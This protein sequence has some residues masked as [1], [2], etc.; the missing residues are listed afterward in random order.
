MS[1]NNKNKTVI[2]T[3]AGGGIGKA[4][5]FEFAK[6]GYKLI[7]IGRTIRDLK[8]CVKEVKTITPNCKAFAVDVTDYSKIKRVFTKILKKDYYVLIN[9][10]GVIKPIGPFEN[11]NI[12]EWT[13]CLEINLIGTANVIHAALPYMKHPKGGTIIN[14]SGGGAF[15]GRPYFTA[16]STSKSAVV[17]FTESL[18]SELTTKGIRVHVVSPGAINTKLF[19][20]MLTAGLRNVGKN[21]W[22]N[23][24]KQKDTGGDKPKNVAE[25]CLWLDSPKS[26]PL[27][28]KALSAVYDDWRNWTKKDIKFLAGNDWYSMRRFDPFTLKKLPKL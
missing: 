3:G 6:N 21:N 15:Y 19:T 2:I 18:A 28:G 11:N 13:K 17:R 25:L 26:K 5:A 9:T 27:T 12:A 8:E 16:Y 4:I 1:K 23:L 10:A 14:F 20:D 24:Q 7:L 22:D